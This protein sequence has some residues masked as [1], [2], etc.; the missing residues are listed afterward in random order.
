[1]M[2]KTVRHT[3]STIGD[4]SGDLART[5]GSGTAGLARRVGD[6]TSDLARRIGTRRALFGLALIGV[7]IGGSIVVVRYL[8]A[9][10]A[11][12]EMDAEQSSFDPSTARAASLNRS[13]AQRTDTLITP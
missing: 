9:R 4:R 7:A 2:T 8:R 6:G 3:I 13:Y 1:M 5:I 11:R 12:N 10:R